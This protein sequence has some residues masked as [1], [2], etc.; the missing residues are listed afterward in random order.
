MVTKT[1]LMTSSSDLTKLKDVL[2]ALNPKA[3]II[4]S[5]SKGNTNK[6]TEANDSRA[7][8]GS[9]MQSAK[10]DRNLASG[11]AMPSFEELVSCQ[12]HYTASRRAQQNV[13]LGTSS[14]FTNALFF[15]ILSLLSHFSPFFSTPRWASSSLTSTRQ[16]PVQGGW[17]CPALTMTLTLM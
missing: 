1:D 17:N 11:A 6:S 13:M 16:K 12:S 4:V 7:T 14:M 5:S 15:V 8:G 10:G 9:A 2:R 3:R